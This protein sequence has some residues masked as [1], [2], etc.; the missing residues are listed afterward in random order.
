VG[1]DSSLALFTTT[2]QQQNLNEDLQALAILNANNATGNVIGAFLTGLTTTALRLLAVARITGLVEKQ[3]S[4]GLHIRVDFAK[5]NRDTIS[6]DIFEARLS[7][8]DLLDETTIQNLARQLALRLIYQ[9]GHGV[10]LASS[11]REPTTLFNR[12]TS[13]Y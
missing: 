8:K 13:H 5:R 4:G 2:F 7:E 12:V 10:R 11:L 3:I 6:V 9:M 1:V